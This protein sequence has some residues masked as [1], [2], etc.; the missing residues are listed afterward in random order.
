MPRTSKGIP[1]KWLM[2]HA[3]YEGTDCLIWPFARNPDGYA[4]MGGER[5]IRIM[6]RLAH[7]EASTKA[8]QAAHSCGNGKGGCVHPKHLRWATRKENALDSLHH[9]TRARGEKQ[10]HAKLTENQV[11]EIRRLY[12]AGGISQSEIGRRFGVSVQAVWDITHFV[13]W[14]RLTESGEAAS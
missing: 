3:T 2:E 4:N 12:N 11:R 7:G 5:P 10:G 1:M 9:G 13:N 14:K 6:C 8:H